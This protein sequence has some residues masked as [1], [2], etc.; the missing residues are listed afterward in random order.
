MTAGKTTG[1]A[2]PGRPP[3]PTGSRRLFRRSGRPWRPRA[4]RKPWKGSSSRPRPPKGTELVVG[5]TFD[6]TFGALV[7]FGLGGVHMEVLGDVTFRVPPLSD[8]DAREMVTGIRGYRL[9]EGY[10]GHPPADVPALEELLLRVSRLVEEVP[11]VVA[12]D[13]NPIIAMP[14]GGGC[15]IVD[16]RIRCRKEPSFY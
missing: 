7:A 2:A 4:R 16:A 10:R 8:L 6:P 13:L 11:E 12:M 5:T 15:L 1:G 9:L 14:P 3:T